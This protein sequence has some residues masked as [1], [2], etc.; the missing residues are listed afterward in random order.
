VGLVGE[1]GCGKS[2]TAR[3]VVGMLPDV[4]EV[5]G[6]AIRFKG[7]DLLRRREEEL[8]D[9][10]GREV[11]MVFQD[12]MTFL[13]PVMKVGLQV[14]EALL[15]QGELSVPE[16]DERALEILRTVGLGDV[17]RLAESY[18]HQL[19]GGMR[20]RVLLGIALAQEPAL[21]IA[22]EPFTALD[23]SIQD[24]LIQLL[25]RM[26]AAL[27][28]SCLL[29]THDLA[30]SAELCDRMYVMYAGEIVE[31]AD[32]ASAY[33]DPRHPYTRSLLDC[34]RLDASMEG[35]IPYIPGSVPSLTAPPGGCRF[36]P[37][38]RHAFEPCSARRPVRSEVGEARWVRCWLEEQG[39]ER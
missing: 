23:V 17:R 11:G 28:F 15:I 12:P 36:H 24:Q 21:L 22:D 9:L 33:E 3:S 14:A 20:Q 32:V 6:G 10:R 30:V 4:A 7:V 1:S 5:V 38:C 29:I 37:R 34:A 16:A 8:T 27:G 39:T 2:M 18:P 13:N 26:Q 31:T 25:K 35:D 19:S